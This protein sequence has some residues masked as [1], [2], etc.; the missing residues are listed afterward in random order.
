MNAIA[1]LLCAALP[2]LPDGGIICTTE[3]PTVRQIM[4]DGYVVVVGKVVATEKPIPR[5]TVGSTTFQV[6]EILRDTEETLA[7]KTEVIV[8]RYW[9]GDSGELDLLYGSKTYSDYWHQPIAISQTSFEY[10]K[11]IAAFDVLEPKRREFYLEYLEHP[12]PLIARD[13]YRECEAFSFEEFQAISPKFPRD[14]LRQ[15]IKSDTTV[16]RQGLYGLMLGLCGDESDAALLADFIKKPTD[17]YRPGIDGVACG[18]LLLEGEK[19]LDLLEEFQLKTGGKVPHAEAY[20][21]LRAIQFARAH[22]DIP[23]DRLKKSMRLALKHPNL[24]EHALEYLILWKDWE[25]QDEV[26]VLYRTRN[27]RML[28]IKRAVARYLVACSR[29]TAMNDDQN[30]VAEHAITA[31]NH[32]STIRKYYPQ[33]VKHAEMSYRPSP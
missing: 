31:K 19:G 21:A 12:D 11:K 6:V 14:K 26:M 4:D 30:P 20:S 7:G 5:Q 27:T 25:A 17:E 16:Y 9:P 29:D 2:G 33:I 8:E 28:D 23:K 22:T 1:L 24:A 10:I 3:P 13:A 15:W 32:L 18:Y